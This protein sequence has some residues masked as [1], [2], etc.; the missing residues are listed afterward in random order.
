MHA[1]VLS[2]IVAVLTTCMA[3]TTSLVQMHAQDNV[4]HDST[5]RPWS[6]AIDAWVI[7]R[8]K[9]DG[10][11]FSVL[12]GEEPAVTDRRTKDAINSRWTR[13]LKKTAQH[14][15]GM[16]HVGRPSG[17]GCERCG[18]TQGRELAASVA[19]TTTGVLSCDTERIAQAANR[20]MHAVRPNSFGARVLI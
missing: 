15:D 14:P 2:L 10:A 20:F 7:A 17:H 18:S 9:R 11:S 12:A 16:R 1:R 19:A 5:G 3:A 8:H 13:H 6:V 4:K